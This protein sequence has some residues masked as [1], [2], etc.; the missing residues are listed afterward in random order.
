M[1]IARTSAS[2]RGHSHAA[3][4]GAQ[5]RSCI[6]IKR[7][8]CYCFSCA[9]SFPSRRALF[10]LVRPSSPHLLRLLSE[11]SFPPNPDVA[12]PLLPHHDV[13]K[14]HVALLPCHPSATLTI[15]I[16]HHFAFPS[17]FP[18]IYLLFPLCTYFSPTRGKLKKCKFIKLQAGGKKISQEPALPFL[19]LLAFLQHR[20]DYR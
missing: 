12:S 5:H 1:F 10:L 4:G 3:A 16:K 18:I 19:R 13:H 7:S 8:P 17:P 9:R 15:P 20:L 6:H 2:Q 14:P 11:M